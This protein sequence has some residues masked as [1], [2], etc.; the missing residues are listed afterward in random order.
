MATTL[1]TSPTFIEPCL[2]PIPMILGMEVPEFEHRNVKR[3]E[4]SV[5][6][7]SIRG[8]ERSQGCLH[9]ETDPNF[10]TNKKCRSASQP[11]MYENNEPP[12]YQLQL[13][14]SHV[15]RRVHPVSSS[16]PSNEEALPALQ[17]HLALLL[18]RVVPCLFQR[19]P[20]GLQRERARHVAIV[21]GQRRRLSRALDV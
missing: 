19:C 9:I 8:H 18:L 13:D 15:Q 7:V 11:M 12:T 5:P 17:C 10:H 1:L 6:S 3:E 16:T 2:M 14:S 4:Q 21:A 20:G